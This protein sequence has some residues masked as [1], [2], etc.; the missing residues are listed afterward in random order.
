M[1]FRIVLLPRGV[2]VEEPPSRPPRQPRRPITCAPRLFQDQYGDLS[3]AID[4]AVPD[5]PQSYEPSI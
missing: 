4:D 3:W 5:C 1:Q 2:E